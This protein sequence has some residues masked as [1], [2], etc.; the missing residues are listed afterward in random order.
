MVKSAK[1]AAVTALQGAYQSY[2]YVILCSS[3][4]LGFP[5]LPGSAVVGP[6]FCILGSVPLACLSLY[7][8]SALV[9]PNRGTHGRCS[10]L[11]YPC[12]FPS[13]ALVEPDRGTHGRCSFPPSPCLFPSPALVEPDRGTHGRC[14]FLLPSRPSSL[15]CPPAPAFVEP[16]CHRTEGRFIVPLSWPTTRRKR[17]AEHD[18]K[19]DARDFAAL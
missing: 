18:R 4:F 2:C 9:K 3:F 12:L 19:H 13:P 6:N 15:L 11:S 1:R 5:V 17:K 16:N 14:S 8:S 10:F 7:L